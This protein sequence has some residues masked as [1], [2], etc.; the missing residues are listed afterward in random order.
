MTDLLL[1]SK[2]RGLTHEQW[3]PLVDLLSPT[4]ANTKLSEDT[5][6]K[7]ARV[8]GVSAV[9]PIELGLDLDYEAILSPDAVKRFLATEGAGMSEH[10]RRN[11]LSAVRL[12]GRA[13][14]LPQY[15]EI[16]A[17]ERIPRNTRNIFY[18]AIENA[19][20]EKAADAIPADDARADATWMV[21]LAFHIGMNATQQQYA[22]GTDVHPWGTHR[23]I[24]VVRPD[25]AGLIERPVPDDLAPA[26]CGRAE[27]VGFRHIVNPNEE[28]RRMY[29]RKPRE[30]LHR[31]DPRLANF[32]VQQAA[33][34]WAVEMF[35][36][37][38]L[39]VA[40]QM[41]G[42][43]PASKTWIDLL[44]VTPSPTRDRYL[45][46]MTKLVEGWQ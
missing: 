27:E 8:V 26:L 42:W 33:D 43:S 14:H 34:A 28:N 9:V 21:K 25:G 10:S 41:S 20:Y 5:A 6:K 44:A 36:R 23:A 45:Q 3:A 1:S 22:C 2:P 30:D 35:H 11:Y 4:L 16:T 15:P 18:T 24:W 7:V 46:V 37:L 31:A 40:V 13:L 38:D 17:K 19:L 12:L 39:G 32:V 29:A